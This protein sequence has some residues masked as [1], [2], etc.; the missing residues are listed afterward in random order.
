MTL[1]MQTLAEQLDT[2]EQRLAELLGVMENL[3]ADNEKL[4]VREQQLQTACDTLKQKNTDASLQ[5]ES[6]ITRLKQPLADKET[7][8]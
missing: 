3:A 6:I 2:L 4:R 1:P 5:I 8:V 7:S